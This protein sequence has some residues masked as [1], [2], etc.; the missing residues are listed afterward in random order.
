MQTPTSTQ[1]VKDSE[2]KVFPVGLNVGSRNV[3]PSILVRGQENGSEAT[4]F[5]NWLQ[6]TSVYL[7]ANLCVPL[8]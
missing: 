5:A 8:R 2:F 6:K 4:D 7:C 1:L 3:N